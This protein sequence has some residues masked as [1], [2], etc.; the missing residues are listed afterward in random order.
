MI[1]RK[2]ATTIP[3]AI[4]MEKTKMHSLFNVEVSNS[5]MAV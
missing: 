2:S 1:A 3:T 4:F 5:I